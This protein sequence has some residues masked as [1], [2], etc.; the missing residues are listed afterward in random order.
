MLPSEPGRPPKKTVM[1][2]TNLFRT[3]ITSEALKPKTNGSSRSAAS[4]PKFAA[5]GAGVPCS[6]SQKITKLSN[7]NGTDR[8]KPNSDP[9]TILT[10][11]RLLF[12][13][14]NVMSFCIDSMFMLRKAIAPT[15][16]KS[17]VHKKITTKKKQAVNRKNGSYQRK[18]RHDKKRHK[19]K[20][21][22]QLGN[23]IGV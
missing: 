22:R 10:A 4:K 18:K 1:L 14:S 2:S 17:G 8:K 15:A 9:N 19:N 5:P 3:R 12:V 11:R 16:P 23:Q 13:K 21:H 6:D 20:Q 7:P